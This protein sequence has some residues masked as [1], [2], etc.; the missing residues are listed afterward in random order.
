MNDVLNGRFT[1]TDIISED[2][3]FRTVDTATGSLAAVKKW[4]EGD[5]S[6]ERELFALTSMDHASAPRYICSF[7]ENGCKYIAEE[8]LEG[9]F[10]SGIP[11]TELI[12]FAVAAAE[13]LCY[14]TSD[15]E[16]MRIH[17]DIKPANLLSC[18]GRICFVDFESSIETGA[19]A[20]DS[21]T[22]TAFKGDKTIRFASEVFTAP[23]VFYGKPCPQSDLY[24][25]GMVLADLLG[26]IGSDGLNLTLIP[27]DE[28]LKPVVKKCTAIDVSARYPN[29]EAFLSD[30]K[31]IRNLQSECLEAIPVCPP[32]SQFSL[33]IDCNVCFAWEFA[34]NAAVSFG[35]KTCVFALTERTQRKLDY[36]ASSEKYYGEE[37]VE[38]AALPYLFDYCSLYKRDA[39]AWHTKGLLHKSE[40]CRHLF[41]SGARLPEELNPENALCISDLVAWGKLN[42][43]CILFVTD[44][45]DDKPVVKNLAESCD[46]TI[47]TPLSNVDDVEACKSYYECFGGNVLYVAWEFRAKCSLPE[48]SIAMIVGEKNYLGAVSHDDERQQKRNFS[49]K[50]RPIFASADSGG[51]AQ[52][53][54]IIHHFFQTACNTMERTCASV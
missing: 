13:F 10:V 9:D 30:L 47:A 29:A 21:G 26:G 48:A 2:R 20:P 39:E 15:T 35:M 52:Y 40:D 49:G 24:S 41:Y 46:Y 7:E 1:V 4:A 32:I 53:V 25:L 54:S 44:R 11:R 12:S 34:W 38:E 27:D 22:C 43:D 42:F 8:W 14:L 28:P 17:G 50:I 33:F 19:D 16:H 36:Y 5:I 51:N 6:F 45:Y 31:Q 3:L 37:C 18:D 23:E